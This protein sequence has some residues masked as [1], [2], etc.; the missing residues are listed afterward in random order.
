MVLL[1]NSD[2]N[3]YIP[4]KSVK[5]NINICYFKYVFKLQ[6]GHSPQWLFISPWVQ[7]LDLYQFILYFLFVC[8]F[9]FCLRLIYLLLYNYFLIFNI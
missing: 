1:I 7:S 3:K 5:H 8:V 2:I 4:V 9:Y 6:F